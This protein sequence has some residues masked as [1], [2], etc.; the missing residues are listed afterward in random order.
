MELL[1][2]IPDSIEKDYILVNIPAFKL[3]IFENKKP[4][5]HTN[6]IVG[7]T[8]NQTQIFKGNIS[9]ILLNPYW[10][11]PSSIVQKEIAPKMRRN[12]KYLVR[13]NMEIIS[14]KPLSIRQKP[15]KNNALG[16]IKFLFPNDYNIYL[17]DTPAKNL[18]EINN[19]AFSHGCIRVENPKKLA[20]YLLRKNTFWNIKKIDSTLLTNKETVIKLKPM[21]PVYIVYFTAWVDKS[22]QI[23]FRNDVYNLDDKIAKKITE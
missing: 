15:G 14:K 20:I 4:I 9:Q 22:E 17:H 3:Y 5:W 16:K 11:I 21:I 23:Y 7:K 12:R 8:A 13:N 10:N 6:V 2:L 19:R 18:F 1:K